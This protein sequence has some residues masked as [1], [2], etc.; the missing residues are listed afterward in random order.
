M[1]GGFEKYELTQADIASIKE[2][3]SKRY[4]QWAWN[5][6]FCEAGALIR[7]RRIKGCGTV[8]AHITLNNDL[9]TD[10]SFRG[11]YFST[12]PPEELASLFIGLPLME[13]ALRTALENHRA[14]DYM[15]G[16]ENEDLVDLLCG[17]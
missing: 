12:L 14:G 13:G 5:Y 11:D 1:A 6:G 17:Q 3:Q 7:K 8:E 2:I 4:D 9:I 15:T 16:L 10:I